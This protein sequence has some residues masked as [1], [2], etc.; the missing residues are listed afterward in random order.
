MITVWHF[1][2]CTQITRIQAGLVA[3]P[4]LGTFI[5][6]LC[7]YLT[8]GAK[9]QLFEIL[10]DIF[11]PQLLPYLQDWTSDVALRLS[12][13]CTNT[14]LPSALL[15]VVLRLAVP[16]P[17]HMDLRKFLVGAEAHT[18]ESWAGVPQ[19]SLIWG[20]CWQ[21][22][23]QMITCCAVLAMFLG[24]EQNC[25]EY[26]RSMGHGDVDLIEPCSWLMLTTIQSDICHGLI[27]GMGG[28]GET[29][30]LV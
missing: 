15:H 18:Q 17:L 27:L 30:F 22:C 9:H 10:T 24:A 19:L 8:A 11:Q 6:A 23:L 20:R 21:Q 28:W 2:I 7:L 3:N 16:S 25:F 29:G 14:P 13:T 12:Y 4:W 5:I 26:C 1:S